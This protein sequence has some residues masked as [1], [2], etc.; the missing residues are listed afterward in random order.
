MYYNYVK[1]NDT[2]YAIE[3]INGDWYKINF[4]KDGKFYTKKSLRL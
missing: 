4:N 1:E 3:Y 2:L